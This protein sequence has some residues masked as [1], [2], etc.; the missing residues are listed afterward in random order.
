[1]GDDYIVTKALMVMGERTI[2]FFRIYV[3]IYYHE[4]NHQTY[5]EEWGAYNMIEYGASVLCPS[6]RQNT[7]ICYINKNH[8]PQHMKYN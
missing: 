3:P 4:K 2:F 7:L 5:K 6:I 1:M 8:F